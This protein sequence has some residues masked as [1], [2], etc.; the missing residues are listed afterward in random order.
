MNYENLL[1]ICSLKDSNFIRHVDV[2]SKIDN[3]VIR[4]YIQ[5]LLEFIVNNELDLPVELYY[6]EKYFGAE[7]KISLYFSELTNNLEL[8]GNSTI[9]NNAINI[10][11]INNYYTIGD[12]IFI[13]SSADFEKFLTENIKLLK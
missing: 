2:L 9:K 11:N 6:Y 8:F 13:D 3:V 4:N 5:W 12:S 1:A 10:C 7:P